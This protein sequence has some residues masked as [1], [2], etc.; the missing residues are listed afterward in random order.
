L[1]ETS[2]GTLST[3]LAA[4][5][6]CSTRVATGARDKVSDKVSDEV[7]DKVSDKVGDK[8]GLLK[9]VSGARIVLDSSGRGCDHSV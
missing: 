8:V 1:S 2:S 7:G 9:Y 5:R 4:G 6:W 3:F